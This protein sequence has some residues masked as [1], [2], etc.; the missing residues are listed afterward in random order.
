MNAEEKAARAE[1]A[2]RELS[3]LSERER[4]RQLEKIAEAIATRRDEILEANRRDVEDAEEMLEKGEYSQVLVDRLKLD[5]K[6]R[7]L[8]EMV[9][10]VAAQ[11]DVI[12]KTLDATE[13][14]ESLELFKVSTPLGV[15]ATIFESRPDALIQI[16]ALCLKSGNSV[17]LKGGSEASRSNRKLYE[18]IKEVTDVDGWIQLVETHEEVD[19]LL[20]LED[21]ID[22]IVPRGSKSL[23]EHIQDNTSIQVL[24]HAE[25]ICHVYIDSDADLEKAVKIVVDAKTDYPAACNAAETLLVHRESADMLQEIVAELDE[26]GVTIVAGNQAREIVDVEKAEEADWSREYGDLKISVKLVSSIQEAVEH[27]DLYGSGHTDA[28]ITEDEERANRFL[29]SVDSSSVMWNASTRFAD[30]YRYGLGAEVG[31]STGKTHA[32]GPVGLEGLTTYKYVLKG[33]GQKVSEFDEKD[34]THRSIND[35]QEENI[36]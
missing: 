32:R 17:V 33:S 6:I 18:L 29:S 28:I 24:G 1:E 10:G 25:G 3:S 22:L 20:E 30:G 26:H 11:E 2:S 15:V 34:Y 16:A 7:S 36:P 9:R 12:G 31:I 5:G 13:L 8:Q 21:Q 35:I 19:Q 27:V 23:I 14:A 4:N